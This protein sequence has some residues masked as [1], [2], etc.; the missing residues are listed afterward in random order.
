MFRC[1]S[2][3]PSADPEFLL[4]AAQGDRVV[5][6]RAFLTIATGAVVMP[7]VANAQQSGKVYRIGILGLDAADPEEARQWQAFRLG[8]RERGW[9]EGGNI[10]IE[11]RWA[12]RNLARVPELAADL[13]RLK[14]DVIVTRGS[15]FVQGARKATS[16]IPIVFTQHA[17]PVGSGHVVS[18]AKPGGNITG[19]AQQLTELY[20]KGLELL[21]SAVP[22]AKRIAVLWNPDAPSHRPGLKAL[23]EAARPLQLQLQ[24]VVAR[25]GADFE[26]AF[27][28]MARA[29]AQALH[30]FATGPYSA[31]RRRLAEFAIRYRL[32]TLFPLREHVEAG[33]LIGYVAD[34][35]DLVRR[36]AIYVDKILK[37]A[38]PADLPVEQASK[39]EL[40]INLKTAKALGLTIPPSL[41]LRADQI[42]E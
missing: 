17:D 4:R 10:L 40:V 28:A 39:F 32:P 11:S 8:L 16:S 20:V 36:G 31:E 19:L 21:I 6:R 26:S 30:V 12:E 27:T 24:P 1:Q 38:R 37:G 34:V 9:I 15:P 14:V 23:E 42:I 2:R 35:S 25:T 7:F 18:L 29:H 3:T 41:L 33:G 5:E 22:G 13:V